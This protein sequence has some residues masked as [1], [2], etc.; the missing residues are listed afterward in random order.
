MTLI[1][2]T[3]IPGQNCFL[4]PNVVP[5]IVIFRLNRINTLIEASEKF[6]KETLL[7]KLE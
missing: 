5:V 1:I 3:L 7:F 4:A 2:M 6:P